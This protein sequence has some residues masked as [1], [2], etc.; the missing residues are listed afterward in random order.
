M[1]EE[2]LDEDF[3]MLFTETIELKKH[4]FGMQVAERAGAI[5]RRE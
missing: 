1:I 3:D 2:E 4:V 5:T